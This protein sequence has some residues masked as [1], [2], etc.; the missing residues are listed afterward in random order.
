MVACNT[1]LFAATLA[2]AVNQ[3][4]A[5]DEYTREL[6]E[7][8]SAILG[9]D[10]IYYLW[11][12][13]ARAG[14]L[15]SQGEL[16]AAENLYLE[17]L[18]GKIKKMGHVRA[19]ATTH[20]Q[21]SEVYMHLHDLD[22]AEQHIRK[23]LDITERLSGTDG[24]EYANYA[25]HLGQLMRMRGDTVEADD[26]Q[27][28]SLALLEQTVGTDYPTYRNRADAT[29]INET[30]LVADEKTILNLREILRRRSNEEKSV[31]YINILH[32]LGSVY[33]RMDA[34]DDAL[35][36]W[37]K[38]V[39]L[40]DEAGLKGTRLEVLTSHSYAVLLETLGHINPAAQT[41]HRYLRALQTGMEWNFM[42]LP[43][44]N[45]VLYW[46]DYHKVI[47]DIQD[48]SLTYYESKPELASMAYECELY[49]KNLLMNTSRNLMSV[50][51][52]DEELANR[53]RLYLDAG[54]ELEE[55]F[56][57][58]IAAGT[59]AG[60]DL[61]YS[62]GGRADSLEQYRREMER[63]MV[64][65]AATDHGMQIE[66]AVWTDVRDALSE[67]QAAVEYIACPDRLN[68]NR[69]RYWALVVRPG[70]EYP[71]IVP[72]G[73]ERHI[74]A[75][76]RGDGGT[77]DSGLSTGGIMESL[78]N[79]LLPCLN[80][81]NEIYI[82]LSGALNTVPL[83]AAVT[84][85]ALSGGR[86]P[87]VIHNVMSTGYLV[88]MPGPVTKNN[89]AVFIGG[90]DY[91]EYG[92]D[93]LTA[94]AEINSPPGYGE[95]DALSAGLTSDG[96]GTTENVAAGGSGTTEQTA[97]N[98][99]GVAQVAALPAPGF[100]DHDTV[101]HNRGQ[102]YDFLP[103]S[104]REVTDCA[105]KLAESGW[106]TD[107][108]T[109]TRATKSRF[110]Q[111]T[112]T[113][114]PRILH[115]STHGFYFPQHNEYGKAGET[116]SVTDSGSTTAGA[117]PTLFE[118]KYRHAD[119]PLMRTGLLLSGANNH[120]ARQ[121]YRSP[122]KDENA[123]GGT[124]ENA[125][126]GSFTVEN[127]GGIISAAEITS[128]WF[129]GTELVVL[130]ACDT[131]IGDTDHSEGVYGL[132]RAFR[133]AGVPN[134]IV[135]LNRV[136]DRESCEFMTGFYTALSGGSTIRESFSA[137]RTAMMLKYKDAPEIWG[138]FKLIE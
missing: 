69:M 51:M 12:L 114:S 37:K 38:C 95:T 70:R 27:Y 10:H 138:A 127:P 124:A 18:D 134:M 11:A 103:W 112:G 91:W 89:R 40:V 20:Y 53:Y 32:E 110:R 6:M 9:Q 36:C 98:R 131:G 99:V 43:E 117:A 96:N 100:P 106:H 55:E 88:N 60:G 113:D 39:E 44:R 136:P 102:G 17:A 23:A 83:D 50:I 82:S 133:I 21:L 52:G 72:L 31:S 66:P 28:G 122:G 63:W 4:L 76:V 57:K 15:F 59:Q 74:L 90:L 30:G 130:S 8:C 71:D 68:D 19:T 101:S 94:E 61:I 85:T 3:P 116:G 41:Y 7:L 121:D 108:V 2:T 5:A 78:W 109:D 34:F 54:R 123:G 77:D 42:L 67:G 45:R 16:S 119:D 120:I 25:W 128:L 118:R 111:Y 58:S 79:P 1:L 97:T 129:G 104:L 126:P 46:R 75:A 107:I 132:Q 105:A 81:S 29:A 22:L 62:P 137:A 48:F 14:L 56:Q 47:K 64:S 125:A 73:L 87:A 135:T 115:I 26:I 13:E 84:Y 80:G 35:E 86:Q 93:W 49:S 24:P 92:E 33:Y 65:R